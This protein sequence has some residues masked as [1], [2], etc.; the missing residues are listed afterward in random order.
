MR[1]DVHAVSLKVASVGSAIGGLLGAAAES[2]RVAA[3]PVP[4]D[5]VEHLIAAIG[6]GGAAG[7]LTTVLIVGTYKAKVD[8]HSEAIKELL[9]KKADTD[10][11]ISVKELIQKKADAEVVEMIQHQVARIDDATQMLVRHLLDRRP[12]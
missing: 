6:L 10:A 4:Q 1:F 5:S 8:S 11:V 3:Q 12:G 2:V 9:Q 7:V